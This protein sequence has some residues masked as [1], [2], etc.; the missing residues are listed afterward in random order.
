MPTNTRSE[1]PGTSNPVKDGAEFD[2]VIVGAGASGCVIA[3]RLSEDPDVSVLVLEAGGPEPSPRL[4]EFQLMGSKFDWKYQ[5]EPE[6]HL[7]DRRI[8]W[9]RGKMYGGSYS[10]SSMQYVRGHRLDYDHWNYL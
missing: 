9:P 1:L 4:D 8:A 2:Y 3:N 5:T 10:M 6:P 7:N